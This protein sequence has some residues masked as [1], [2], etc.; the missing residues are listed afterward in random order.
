MYEEV[1]SEFLQPLRQITRYGERGW[2][3]RASPGPYLVQTPGTRKAWPGADKGLAS[4][5]HAWMIM[6]PNVAASDRCGAV[7]VRTNGG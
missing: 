6:L 4:L 2:L 7:C 1:I 3:L 5:R